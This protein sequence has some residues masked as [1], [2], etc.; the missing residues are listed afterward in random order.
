[1]LS[2]CN[3]DVDCIV[4]HILQVGLEIE[5][6]D[7]IILAPIDIM[8]TIKSSEQ[9]KAMMYS[10]VCEDINV[11]EVDKLRC[12]N[13]VVVWNLTLLQILIIGNEEKEKHLRCF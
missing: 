9:L 13:L 4:L 10:Y 3:I 1:M 7:N 6:C 2:V 11:F 8:T 12:R 5:Q